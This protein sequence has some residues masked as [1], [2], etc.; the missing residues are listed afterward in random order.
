LHGFTGWDQNPQLTSS[1][2]TVQFDPDLNLPLH[3][4]GGAFYCAL[5]SHQ[6]PHAPGS[7]ARFDDK[8]HMDYVMAAVNSMTGVRELSTQLKKRLAE[9]AGRVCKDRDKR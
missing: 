4:L 2:G 8:R 7:P 9:R 3:I 1:G 6:T 5:K